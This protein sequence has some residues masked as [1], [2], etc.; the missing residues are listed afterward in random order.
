MGVE[1]SDA[2]KARAQE[3][4]TQGSP[5]YLSRSQ[6]GPVVTGVMDSQ[7]G[8]IFWGTNQDAVPAHLNPLLQNR[9][10]AYL[11]ATGS[12]IPVRAGIPGTHSEIVA[13]NDALNARE[14]ATGVPVT[15]DDL[16]SFLLSNRSLIGQTR[17]VGI[18]PRCANCFSLTN[19]VTV[20]GG[21]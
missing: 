17:V 3:I 11:E 19:G 16:G 14:A 6:R 8:E 10:D 15:E 2:V 18:P 1:L 7:T 4:S 5:S 12:N 21:N 20:I 9:L 13:L